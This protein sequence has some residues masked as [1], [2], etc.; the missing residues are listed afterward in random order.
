MPLYLKIAFAAAFVLITEPLVAQR[1]LPAQPETVGMSSGR[2]E[3]LTESLQDYVDDNRLAGAVAL[4]V[5]RGKIAYLEAV[6]FRDKE[7][8]A[9]ML[10]DTIF[11]I[12]SQTKALVSVGVMILQEE[13][14]LLITDSVGKYLPE[15]M[16][17]TVAEPNDRE[18]YSVVAANRP[19]TIQDLLTHTAGI[20]YGSGPASKE[21]EDAAI[22]GWY[23]ANR[24]ESVSEVMNRLAKLPFDAHPGEQWIYGYNTDILGALIEQISGQTLADFLNARLFQPLQLQDS[25]FFLPP[26]KV[27]RLA[28][29]YSSTD[30][31]SVD[32]APDPGHKAA[33]PNY[34]YRCVECANQGSY[35]N[36]PRKSFSGGAGLLST[37]TDYATFLQML[38]NGGALQGKRILTRKTVELMTVDHTG[39]IAYQ[40]GQ[41][42]G[43][44]FSIIQDPAATGLPSSVGEYGWG[45]AYHSTYW[46]D[47]AEELIVVYM[48]QLIP[49]IDIDDHGKL[50]TLI[51]QSIID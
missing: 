37:A 10:T 48:T 11:R 33:I 40:P 31:G 6:G 29:V 32:R 19:I 21:W 7:T 24:S 14:E 34:G 42:F 36:G 45:G 13:G 30:D 3:R 22:T 23:F 5:R 49:A 4:V 47:P 17:T 38:L 9:P 1:L 44:G 12:A 41:G 8:D 50:R 43:L 28:T 18:S 39:D 46:V 16:D 15:F 27:D 51:Y 35:I 25:H 2:L 20:S 26:E